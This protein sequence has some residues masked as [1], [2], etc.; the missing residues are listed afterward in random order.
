MYIVP[1]FATH[2]DEVE[3]DTQSDAYPVADKTSVPSGMLSLLR[4]SSKR[5]CVLGTDAALR[6]ITAWR[7]GD[8]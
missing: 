8:I 6:F 7:L 2:P 1:R 5:D 3:R 4:Y